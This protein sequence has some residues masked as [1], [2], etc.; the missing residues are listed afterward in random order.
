MALAALAT[1]PALSIAGFGRDAAAR[2]KPSLRS[3]TQDDLGIT[4]VLGL[5]GLRSQPCVTA[6]IP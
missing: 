2:T 6:T 1:L 5:P 3:M 4:L